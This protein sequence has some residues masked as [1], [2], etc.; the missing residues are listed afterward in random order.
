MDC[1][2]SLR[3]LILHRNGTDSVNTQLTEHQATSPTEE[4]AQHRVP[5]CNRAFFVGKQ[6]SRPPTSRPQRTA[7]IR[8]QRDGPSTVSP[9]PSPDSGPAHP[10][11]RSQHESG[12]PRGRHQRVHPIPVAPRRAF[13]Q[14]TA[15]AHRRDRTHHSSRDGDTHPPEQ[16]GPVRPDA[17]PRPHGATPR[18]PRCCRHGRPSIGGSHPAAEHLVLFL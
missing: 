8:T 18:R 13:P 9:Y 12:C 5:G 2:S 16:P 3:N 17:G 10:R 15:P 4:P 1:G 7:R 11:S 6:P 14:R